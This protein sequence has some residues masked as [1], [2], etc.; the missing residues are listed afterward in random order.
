MSAARTNRVAVAVCDRTGEEHGATFAEST[1]IINADGWVVAETGPGVGVAVADIDLAASRGKR[2]T[3]HVD[4][5][6]DR[7]LDLY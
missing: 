7:R 3:D 1:A 5:L 6:A 2:L 4:V